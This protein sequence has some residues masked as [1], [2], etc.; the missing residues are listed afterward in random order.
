MGG[1]CL[2][3]PNIDGSYQ[4]IV[5]NKACTGLGNHKSASILKV[6]MGEGFSESISE[7]L[8]S[9]GFQRNHG[10][11]PAHSQPSLHAKRHDI[12]ALQRLQV[13]FG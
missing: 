5:D 7:T 10:F 8:S 2:C 3:V 11:K 9:I 6:A 4:L 13:G 12:A 1:S